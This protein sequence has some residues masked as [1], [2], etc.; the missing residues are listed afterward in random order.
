MHTLF[1]PWPKMKIDADLLADSLMTVVV[2]WTQRAGLD[3]S[4]WP[5][6]KNG[7][8]QLLYEDL[9]TWHSELKKAAISSTHLFYRLKPAPG[10]EC[11]DCV[12]FVQNATT[13]LLTQSLFLRDGVDENGKTRNFAHPALKD[14]TIKFFYTGSYHIAQQRTDIFWSHIPNTCLVVMCTA[15]LR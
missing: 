2:Q 11:P 15:V 9:S 12:A 6:K 14:V 8:M 3:P 13:A 7:M 4:Y 5:E 10:I 1:N